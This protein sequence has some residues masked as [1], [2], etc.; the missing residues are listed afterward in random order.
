MYGGWDR[1]LLYLLLVCLVAG[2]KVP[3][4]ESW[5]LLMSS[6]V[7]SVNVSLSCCFFLTVCLWFMLSR[8][9]R[10]VINR[11]AFIMFA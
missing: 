11:T 8:N 5:V 4:H 10:N 9:H 1:G 2:T 3:R 6:L 7:T